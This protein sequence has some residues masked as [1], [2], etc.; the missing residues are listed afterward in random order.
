M[1]KNISPDIYRIIHKDNLEYILQSGKLV[2]SSH[3][4][5]DL[6]YKPIGE[7]T[8]IQSRKSKPII[9]GGNNY[10]I[11][12]DYIP[13]FFGQRPVMLYTIQRGFDVAKLQSQELINF[14]IF[15]TEL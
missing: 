8:L 14:T 13:F 3:P 9:I 5:H 4:D 1:S 12:S 6:N 10:G 11:L 15:N 2:I 7:T